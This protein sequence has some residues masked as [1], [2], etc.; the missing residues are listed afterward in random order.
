MNSFRINLLLLFSAVS[1][2]SC[3][4]LEDDVLP[5][6][7]G[8]SGD[9]IV[10]MDSIY[11]AGE[12]G[13]TLLNCFAGTQDGLP[14]REP[15]F[16]VI[17]VTPP[18]FKQIFKTT[19]NIVVVTKA[20][21][22]DKPKFA[23]QEN[24]WAKNQLVLTLI[25]DKDKT[26]ADIL[27]KNCE[28]LRDR[29]N[30]EESKRLQKAFSK[31]KNEKIIGQVNEVI[32]TRVIIPADYLLAK[33]ESNVVWLRK[34]FQHNGH[35]I[36]MGLI[37]YK[38]PYISENQLF[39]DSILN[40]RD[41]ITR[42][43]EG[44]VDGSYMKHYD[45]FLPTEKNRSVNARFVKEL[46]GLWNMENAFMGGPFINFAF[47]DASGTSLINI[48]GYVFAPKFDKREYLRE[49]EAIALTALN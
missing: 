39:A 21:S 20:G 38:T 43:V 42:M 48:D 33:K 28:K 37:I 17:Q 2:L 4:S 25:T 10:V 14:Q 15:Y 12:T 16:N 1:L 8:K 6:G 26:A 3:V 5:Q 27:Q 9:I 35:Q 41:L 11:W 40:N 13:N 7:T 19:K 24:L 45:E 31:L 44:P 23:L 34:D 30:L 32:G 18:N 49:L 29:F 22:S 36:N 47:I 46:R